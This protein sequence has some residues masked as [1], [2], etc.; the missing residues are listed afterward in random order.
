MGHFFSPLKG[1]V[2]CFQVLVIMNKT[3]M[4]ICVQIFMSTYVF[5]A[6]IVEWLDHIVNACLTLQETAK[7]F[8]KCLCHF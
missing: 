1:S 3:A 5:M 2:N 7:P 8:L 4:N 6:V